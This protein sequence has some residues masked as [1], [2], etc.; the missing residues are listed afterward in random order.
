MRFLIF[1]DLHGNQYAWNAFQQTLAETAY[2]RLVFLGDIFGYYYG[3]REL[4]DA[5]AKIKDLIWLRG[6]H[7]QFLLDLLHA[8]ADADHLVSRYGSTYLTAAAAPGRAES[9][10]KDKPFSCEIDADGRRI[11]F[12]HGT[13]DDPEAGRLYPKDKWMPELCGAYD[14]VI[15][16]HTH[17]RMVREGGGKLWFNAGSLGQPRDGNHPGALLF[18]SGTGTHEYMDVLYDKT[19]LL[20]EIGEKDPELEKLKEILAREK[21]G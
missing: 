10:L 17:F 21:D 13:P 6:N 7:D 4:L 3:Q 2:D 1:S 11:L 19:E 9:L 20:R 14:V 8:R 5:L 12:C 16:G 15:C 18:D